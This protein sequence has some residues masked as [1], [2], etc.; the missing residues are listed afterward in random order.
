[1]GLSFGDTRERSGWTTLPAS[2]HSAQIALDAETPSAAVVI[3]TTG[4][5]ASPDSS[6]LHSYAIDIEVFPLISADHHKA[7]ALP[8]AAHSAGPIRL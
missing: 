1:M 2:A 6:M 4:S 7:D 5:I 8:E 3:H